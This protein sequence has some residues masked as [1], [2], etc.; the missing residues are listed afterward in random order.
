MQRRVYP[1]RLGP[2]SRREEVR[3]RLAVPLENS[4][5]APARQ[6]VL[7]VPRGSTALAMR[8]SAHSVHPD[9]M[10]RFQ[11][12]LLLRAV[13]YVLLESTVCSE[14]LRACRARQVDFRPSTGRENVRCAQLDNTAAFPAPTQRTAAVTAFQRWGMCAQR[15]RRLHWARLVQQGSTALRARMDRAQHVSPGG[16]RRRRLTGIC[17]KRSTCVLT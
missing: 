1:A 7:A 5:A 12:G 2:R 16:G 9:C 10:A 6:L 11:T 17:A 4:S 13:V 8:A 14:A 15:E 3:N